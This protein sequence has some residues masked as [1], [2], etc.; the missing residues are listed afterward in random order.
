[1]K[2]RILKIIRNINS[3]KP[4]EYIAEKAYVPEKS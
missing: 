3:P 1:M 4:M 2:E